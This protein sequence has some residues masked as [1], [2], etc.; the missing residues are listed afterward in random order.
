MKLSDEQIKSAVDELKY[1][2]PHVDWQI[3]HWQLDDVVRRVIAKI[4]PAPFDII[5]HMKR[6]AAFSQK[7]FGPGLR[8][9]GV[10]DHIRKELAEIE[11]EPRDLSEWID[12][13]ILGFDGA[14]R[15]AQE[16]GI[17]FEQVVSAWRAKQAKNETRKWPDWRT[18]DPE[19]A[20]EHIREAA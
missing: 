17:P 6:Q 3:E 19:K 5:E 10:V 9:K 2:L 14:L 16:E 1:M 12:V 18:A 7:N 13:I 20:I 11:K 8:T 4:S 15:L